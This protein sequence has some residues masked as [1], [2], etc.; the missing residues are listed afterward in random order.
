MKQQQNNI[1]NVEITDSV[2]EETI[3]LLKPKLALF[4]YITEQTFKDKLKSGAYKLVSIHGFLVFLEYIVYETGLKVMEVNVI[5][6][7]QDVNNTPDVMREALAAVEDYCSQ[8][9][10]DRFVLDGRTGWKRV[11]PDYSVEKTIL[12]KNRIRSNY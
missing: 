3:R 6:S 12:S 5:N 2:C 10:V 7:D 4:D 8:W 1:T 11:F 9:E